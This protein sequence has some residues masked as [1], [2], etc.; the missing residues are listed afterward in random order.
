MKKYSASQRKGG[1]RS[2]GEE[3]RAQLSKATEDEVPAHTLGT[4][5]VSSVGGNGATALGF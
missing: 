5:T 3:M 2:V 4:G 1:T